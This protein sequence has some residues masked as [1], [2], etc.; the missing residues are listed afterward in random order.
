LKIKP[1]SSPKQD[2]NSSL[3]PSDHQVNISTVTLNYSTL[4]TTMK[5]LTCALRA[6][7]MM[8]PKL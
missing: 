8:I 1:V 7:Y 6:S 2:S 4:Y 5:C 3:F